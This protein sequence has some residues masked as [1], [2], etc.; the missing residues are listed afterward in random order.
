MYVNRTGYFLGVFSAGWELGEHVQPV[1]GLQPA[2]SMLSEH[3]RQY[4]SKPIFHSVVAILSAVHT[5]TST[6]MRAFYGN[7]YNIHATVTVPT[8][9][10]CVSLWESLNFS[11]QILFN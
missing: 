6:I 11:K 8:V 9:F 5:V 7:P 2:A 3:A 4:Y 10:G 1:G